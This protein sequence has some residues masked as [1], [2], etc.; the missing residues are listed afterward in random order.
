M[1]ALKTLMRHDPVCW[2]TQNQLFTALSSLLLCRCNDNENVSCDRIE[3][4]TVGYSHLS[5]VKLSVRNIMCYT[6]PDFQADGLQK[7][8]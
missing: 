6:M 5:N 1:A 3:V 7:D 8:Q 4:R 2:Q